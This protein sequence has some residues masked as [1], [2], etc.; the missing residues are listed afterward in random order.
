[1]ALRKQLEQKLQEAAQSRKLAEQEM[2]AARAI[3]D[4]AKLADAPSVEAE[5]AHA[6]EDLSSAIDTAKKVWKR[7]EK[8]LHEHL[9][10]R[11]TSAQSLIV[12]SKNI[13]KDVRLAE[14]PPARA[15]AAAGD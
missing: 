8:V 1:M 15:R 7:L 2:E 6:A 4:Q 10:S 14:G 11:F 12:A 3:I 5:A 13:G 9:S